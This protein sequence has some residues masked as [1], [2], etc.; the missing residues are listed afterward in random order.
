VYDKDGSPLSASLKVAM[1]QSVK[2]KKTAGISAAD[3]MI[4]LYENSK[5]N[6]QGYINGQNYVNIDQTSGDMSWVSLSS[7]DSDT[8]QVTANANGTTYTVAD[9]TNASKVYQVSSKYVWHSL[10]AVPLDEKTGSIGDPVDTSYRTAQIVMS[11]NAPTHM[12]FNGVMYKVELK[13]VNLY[14]MTPINAKNKSKATL[15]MMQD[16]N[17]TAH[18]VQVDDGKNSYNYL[19]VMD[20]LNEDALNYYRFKIQGTTTPT[21]HAFPVGPVIAKQLMIGKRS[22][23]VSVPKETTHVLFVKDIPKGSAGLSVQSQQHFMQ[24]LRIMF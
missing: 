9:A 6:M 8:L 10:F 20:S 13:S 7:N 23:T 17:T 1:L 11:G 18:Y 15:K 21:T 2:S 4:L 19:Y 3:D 22:V 24:T 12:L 14:N 5:N 16:Q